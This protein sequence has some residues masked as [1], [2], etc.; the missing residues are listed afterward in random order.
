V[1]FL[2]SSAIQNVF[3]G[4]LNDPSADVRDS[5]AKFVCKV[6][7]IYGEGL[8]KIVDKNISNKDIIQKL[9]D[10]LED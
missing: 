1:D 10:G 2:K 4:L 8:F 6:R 9:T 5:T 3:E 7:A